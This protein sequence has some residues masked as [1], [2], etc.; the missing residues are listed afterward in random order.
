M[1]AMGR[2]RAPRASD[3]EVLHVSVTVDADA[4]AQ[5]YAAQQFFCDLYAVYQN[6]SQR[7]GTVER[8]YAIAD[9]VVRLQFAGDSLVPLFAPAFAHLAHTGQH[10]DPD[11][12]VCL[13]DSHSTGVQM[14]PRPWGREDSLA[15][16]FVRGY[17]DERF[18]TALCGDSGA[19]S[20]LDSQQHLALWWLEASDQITTYERGAPLRSILHWWMRQHG[21]LLVH[22][23]AIG[24]P[25]GGLLLA[26][27]GGSGKS[28]TA[29]VS[30]LRGWHYLA[31]DY[32]LLST[33]GDPRAYSVY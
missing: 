15:H 9:F 25:H 26:G 7:V 16:G 6:A 3:A 31:D 20:M 27:K 21:R 23:A 29:L 28:T 1:A 2:P 5:V 33:R 17:N 22:A 24:N 11:L 8:Q 4:T 18:Q 32:C 19:L 30:A 10:T 13:W 12:T 14:P